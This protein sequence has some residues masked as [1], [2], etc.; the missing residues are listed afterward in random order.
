VRV[1]F[2]VLHYGLLRNFTSVVRGLAARGHDVALA[3][4]EPDTMGGRELAQSLRDAS[5][6][7]QLL[8]PPALDGDRVVDLGARVRVALDYFRFHEPPYAASPKLRERLRPRVPRLLLHA[9]PRI[10]RSRLV[11]VL[12]S[13]ERSL[14]PSPVLVEW[15]RRQRPDVLLLGSLTHYRSAAPEIH[16]AA[17]ALG[18]PTAACIYS[19]DHLSSKALLR[20]RP[21]RVLVWNEVQADEAMRLHGIPPAQIAVTGAQCYDHWVTAT[22]ARDREAFCRAMG[23]DPARPYLL[24]VC[25][26]LTPSPD[27][28]GFVRE[29]LAAIRASSHPRVR[30]MGVLIRPHPERTREWT[31]IAPLAP[32]VVVRAGSTTS[33]AGTRDYFDAMYHADGVVGLV[34]SAFL[35]AAVI[36]RPVF[37]VTLPRFAVH[38]QAM[39]H[40]R[41]LL[42]VADGLPAVASTLDEH[43]A[44][45][46]RALD[47]SDSWRERQGAFLRAFVRP[48]TVRT[49]ATDCFIEVVEGMHGALASEPVVSPTRSARLALRAAALGPV[50]RAMLDAVEAEYASGLRRKASVKRQK[51]R[52]K[53]TRQ[54]ASA[55]KRWLLGRP[56][57]EDRL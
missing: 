6:R 38:Q 40:F 56:K 9:E 57:A 10:G 42:E 33:E 37:T 48:E 31:G 28:P 54:A 43:V 15:L 3:A 47:G 29:W 53:R 12:S 39:Q 13:I 18:V 19:W 5:A 22:P 24:Y 2:A 8:E 50:R 34:T 7:V 32:N 20:R 27:E 30:E 46:G 23:L 21:E 26:A 25:S 41:Y 11:R 45:I 52:S 35:D 16:R 51:A 49:T 4:E 14:P 44:Q 1:V 55:A 17:I 36:G